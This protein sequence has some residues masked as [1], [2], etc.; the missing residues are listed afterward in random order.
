L[1]FFSSSER[2][3]TT[4]HPK[5]S[6]RTTA[7][8]GAGGWGTALAVL[9]AKGGNAVTLWGNNA[10]RAGRL[11]ETR[12]NSEYLP[13]V[14]IPE[15]I[16]VTSEIAD[17]AGAEL[18]VFVTP[19]VALRSVA[20]RLQAAGLN[21][22]AVFLSG[23]KGIEHGT[24]KRMSEVL[25]EIF[26]DNTIAVLS[27]PNLAAEIARD[28]PAAAVLGCPN[29]QCAEELQSY[30]G[31]E[32]FRIYSSDETIGI[33]LGGALK[34]VFAIAAGASDGFGLGDN[35]KAALVTRSLAELLRLGTAMG[36]NP[37]TFYGLS[38]AGDLIATCFSQLS[39]NRRVGERLGRG[40][41]LAQITGSSH[42]VAEGIPTAKSA[43][44]CARKLG[45]ETPI[46]DQ[47]YSVVHE[48][49]QPADAMQALLA[50]DQKAERA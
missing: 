23:T 25:H 32:R 45:I 9:W 21:G 40:E 42:M 34:N 7:I 44:E 17:C 37:R 12:E 16:A 18:I 2:N 46:I 19:S 33:E 28:A 5:V 48:G 30:L 22:G 15:S 39:R 13:G 20:K 31:S 4:L 29:H 11:R 38:G 3:R 14:K 36:G 10:E 35:S 47:I 50:R 8:L 24:G 26:P 49:K 41:T 6:I 27:G 1:E 43:Y